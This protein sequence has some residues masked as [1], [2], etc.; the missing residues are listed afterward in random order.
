MS[1][2]GHSAAVYLNVLKCDLFPFCT[3]APLSNIEK[4]ESGFISYV[5]INVVN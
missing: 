5:F 4:E 2:K 1:F 3:L